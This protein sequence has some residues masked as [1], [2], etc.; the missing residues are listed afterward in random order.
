MTKPKNS[1]QL[2]RVY[3]WYSTQDGTIHI[4][5]DD[6]RIIDE[7]GKY[8][9]LNIAISPRRQPRTFRWLDL[10]LRREGIRP[11]A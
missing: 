9:G 11:A 2:E 5:S 10:L 7:C 1:V 6:H 8:M 3:V 4:S